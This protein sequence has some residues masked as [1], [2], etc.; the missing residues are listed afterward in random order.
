MGQLPM[1]IKKHRLVDKGF[2]L[3]GLFFIGREKKHGKAK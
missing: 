1:A 3:G 2:F